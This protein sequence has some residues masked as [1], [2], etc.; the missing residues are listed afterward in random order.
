MSDS[1][2]IDQVYDL[3]GNKLDTYSVINNTN[4]EDYSIKN[5]E[6]YPMILLYTNDIMKYLKKTN[7]QNVYRYNTDTINE[8]LQ[9]NLFISPGCIEIKDSIA[10]KVLLLINKNF[11][12]KKNNK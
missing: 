4:D 10:P 7:T 5:I 1:Y 2:D 3:F 9:T 12:K 6:E 11:A 8:L